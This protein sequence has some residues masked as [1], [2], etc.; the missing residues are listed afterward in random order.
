MASLAVLLLIKGDSISMTSSLSKTLEELS[1]YNQH[2]HVYIISEHKEILFE[3]K[4]KL[5]EVSWVPIEEELGGAAAYNKALKEVIEDYILFTWPGS[6]ISGVLIDG[7]NKA[8]NKNEIHALRGN[9][10]SFPYEPN[11]PLIHGWMMMHQLYELNQLLIPKEAIHKV[12]EMDEQELLDKDFDWEYILR[13]SKYYPF[14]PIGIMESN[15]RRLCADHVVA[16]DVY[17]THAYILRNRNIPFGNDK[18]ICKAFNR[19][20]GTTKK[21]FTWKKANPYKIAIVGGYWDYHHN[22]LCFFNPLDTLQGKAFG[23]Y[24]VFM[25][26]QINNEDVKDI[27]LVIFS[28]CRNR[29]I[30]EIIEYCKLHGIQTAYMI[31]DNWLTISK[32]FPGDYGTMFSPGSPDY[33]IFMEAIKNC[34]AI[35]TYSDTLFSTLSSINS[36]TYKFPLNIQPIPQIKR[37][38]SDELMIGYMGSLRYDSTAFYGLREAALRH[39]KCTVLLIG[40]LSAEQRKLFEG[41][42]TIQKEYMAYHHYRE[43]IQQVQPDILI[44]PLE[45]NPTCA[46]KC[47]NKYLEIGA[48]HAAGVYSNVTPYKE[49]VVHGINGYLVIKESQEAWYDA[50]SELINDQHLRCKI[51]N[52]A[53]EQVMTKYSTAS[54]LNEFCSKLKEII[55]R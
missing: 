5:T 11:K 21:R 50:I 22:Q 7:V 13:L 53:Y 54:I 55:N 47:A 51:Q 28:R 49:E 38:D 12:G 2:I 26:A 44:A 20:M 36:N 14:N 31:D 29:K 23:T 52:A 33:D 48:M 18:E 45:D 37:E 6:R 8:Y 34:D 1:W 30:L 40:T 3:A 32:D 25:D 41:I 4:E 35:I 39:K 27:D 19:D 9:D 46:S 10:Y 17:R 15:L 24:R 43:F 42:K 16:D